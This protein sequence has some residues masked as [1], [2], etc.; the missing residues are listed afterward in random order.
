[1]S[2][3]LNRVNALFSRHGYLFL[4]IT[5]ILN[6]ILIKVHLLAKLWHACSPLKEHLL[7]M[8]CDVMACGRGG[9]F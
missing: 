1:M 2:P 3:S 8:W 6:E 4:F 9:V 5:T 7:Y